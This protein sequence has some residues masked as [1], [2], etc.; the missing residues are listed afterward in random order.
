MYTLRTVQIMCSCVCA[1]LLT[2]AVGLGAQSPTGFPNPDL[3]IKAPSAKGSAHTEFSPNGTGFAIYG[4]PNQTIQLSSLSL[5]GDS[6]LLAAG[7]TPGT[8]DLW[9]IP[10]HRLLK[11]FPAGNVAVLSRDGSIL[12]TASFSVIDVRTKKERCRFPWHP[13]NANA[14]VNRMHL[15][16][17][18][19]LLAVTINGSNILVVDTDTCKRVASL[20]RTRDGD[21]TPDGAKF[22][23]ANY[24]VMTLWQVDG[25]KLL[26]TFPAG[27]DYTTGLVVSPNGQEALIAGPNDAKL[28][29]IRDGSTI[30][31]FGEGW[32]SAVG[33]LSDDVLLVRDQHQLAFWS[34]DGRL[35]CS[36]SKA[37]SGDVALA[38]DGSL[39]V[40]A[41]HQRD[42]LFWSAATIARACQSKN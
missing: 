2:A 6:S 8:V 16:P 11:T 20:D 33:F 18:G 42:V 5:S 17:D 23:A 32:V 41:A 4:D 13:E 27:P 14:T 15:S 24:Q 36:D 34:T 25:W 22:F 37:E 21:F 35:L 10:K 30:R 26:A 38:Q 19:K 40:G 3:V 29:R 39:A 28:V 12:A 9:D 7:A 1:A 31:K